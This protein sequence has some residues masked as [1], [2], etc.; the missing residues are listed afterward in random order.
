MD[1]DFIKETVKVYMQDTTGTFLKEDI[2]TV[3]VTQSVKEDIR[4]SD[5]MHKFVLKETYPRTYPTIDMTA[6]DRVYLSL[7]ANH[8]PVSGN[9]STNH[10]C[11]TGGYLSHC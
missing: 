11:K 7:A 5:T 10:S 8:A 4:F 9:I 2:L 3:S 6:Q 1:T